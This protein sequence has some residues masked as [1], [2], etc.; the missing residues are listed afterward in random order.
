MNR[1]IKVIMI[2]IIIFFL[3][4]YFTKYSSDYYEMKSNLTEEAIKKYEKDLKEGKNI[5]PSNYI[6]EEKNYNNKA[7]KLGL[8][9]SHLIEKLVDDSFK[10]MMKYLEEGTKS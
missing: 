4:L 2:I 1:L 7:S 6:K 3:S 10:Y 5:I 8:S 9:L